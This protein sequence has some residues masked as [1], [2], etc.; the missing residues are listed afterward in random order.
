MHLG[1][2][3]EGFSLEVRVGLMF[4]GYYFRPL[5]QRDE[6]GRTRSRTRRRWRHST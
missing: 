2:P 1:K 5:S 6:V 3:T 4:T